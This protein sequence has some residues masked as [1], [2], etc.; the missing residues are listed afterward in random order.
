TTWVG[1]GAHTVAARGA[2]DATIVVEEELRT[3][4]REP[5]PAAV[6]SGDARELA[7]GSFRPI[8]AKGSGT[9]VLYRLPGG[10]LVLRLEGFATEPNPDL[11]VWLSTQADPT[12][13]RR[14]FEA[15]HVRVRSLKATIG[16]QNYPL[17]ANTD[18][19]AI[20]SIAVVNPGQRIGYAAARLAR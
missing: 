2:G 8:E 15:R 5:A 1:M 11:V 12:T 7:R 20:R 3:P 4:L 14:V 18:A 17:P 10:R 9:A 6:R 16:D 19:A 13:T